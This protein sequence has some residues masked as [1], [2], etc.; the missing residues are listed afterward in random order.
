MTLQEEIGKFMSRVC[1]GV[2]SGNTDDTIDF[3]YE[4]LDDMMHAGR[5]EDLELYL[6]SVVLDNKIDITTALSFLVLSNWCKDKLDHRDMFVKRF[7]TWLEVD[8]K[9]TLLESK[10]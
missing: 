4:H 5:F 3:I 2:S 1:E 8:L 9:E 6:D 7:Q 10:V